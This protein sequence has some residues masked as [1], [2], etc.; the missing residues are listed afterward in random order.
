ML[1]LSNHYSGASMAGGL[2]K[3]ETLTGTEGVR[4]QPEADS[5]RGSELT[6]S[7]PRPLCIKYPDPATMGPW[8]IMIHQLPVISWPFLTVAGLV[9]TPIGWAFRF[10]NRIK[11]IANHV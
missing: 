11:E 4:S 1:A 5:F 10:A 2:V 7:L 8:H 3:R 6:A 9:L